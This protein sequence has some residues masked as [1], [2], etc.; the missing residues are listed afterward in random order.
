VHIN[1]DYMH[2]LSSN[3][4]HF[5]TI[6]L[7]LLLVNAIFV[8]NNVLTNDCCLLHGIFV[9]CFQAIASMAMSLYFSPRWF[10]LRKRRIDIPDRVEYMFPEEHLEVHTKYKGAFPKEVILGLALGSLGMQHTSNPH[11]FEV[12]PKEG[13]L[14]RQ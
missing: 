9:M 12:W 11:N 8:I 1:I 5:C 6:G 13:G 3:F 2:E 14:G 7:L 10:C 4:C